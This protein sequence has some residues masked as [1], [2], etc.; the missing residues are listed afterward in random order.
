MPQVPPQ[1]SPVGPPPGRVPPTIPGPRCRRP[2][3]PFPFRPWKGNPLSDQLLC[4]SAFDT[5]IKA[6]TDE[7][8]GAGRFT[9]LVSVFGN[10]D[11]AGDVVMPGAFRRT[12]AEWRQKGDALPCVWNHDHSDPF[13]HIGS[14]TDA[15]ETAEGLVVEGQLDIA[16]NPKAAQVHRLL[17]GRRIRAFSFAYG[18]KSARPGE[19]NGLRVNELHD[20]DLLEVGPVWQ[21]CNPDARL[22]DVK[23]APEPEPDPREVVAGWLAS[24]DSTPRMTPLGLARWAHDLENR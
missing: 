6:V 7:G 9:A 21:G 20:L 23:A 14:V 22:L 15:T 11:K 2:G 12:L 18:V 3:I 10:I 13:S 16:G 4:K 1:T 19:R 24:L 8:D 5:K 17:R